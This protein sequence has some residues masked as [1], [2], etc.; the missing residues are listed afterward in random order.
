MLMH[1]PCDTLNDTLATYR[2]IE[3]L[4][5]DGCARAIGVSKCV[6]RICVHTSWHCACC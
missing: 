2:V 4:V 5:F 3:E 1:W 6:Q